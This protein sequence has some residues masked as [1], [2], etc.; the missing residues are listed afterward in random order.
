[1]IS[2]ISDRRL[3]KVFSVLAKKS[4]MHV[5]KRRETAPTDTAV[6]DD[7]DANASTG[8]AVHIVGY[9]K[10]TRKMTRVAEKALKEERSTPAEEP[11]A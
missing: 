8:G 5:N 3:L 7:G 9:T 6:E 2:N 11:F 1:M 10:E 4:T